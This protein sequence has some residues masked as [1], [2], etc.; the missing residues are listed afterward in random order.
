MADVVQAAAGAGIGYLAGDVLGYPAVGS[1]IGAA[2]SVTFLGDAAGRVVS[3][4]VRGATATAER[5]L[6]GM[7]NVRLRSGGRR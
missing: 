2:L 6:S 7:G 4:R 3:S 1:M 5:R